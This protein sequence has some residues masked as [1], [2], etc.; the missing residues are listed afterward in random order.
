MPARA[1]HQPSWHTASCPACGSHRTRVRY[2]A[3]K[4]KQHAGIIVRH[5]EC[6]CGARWETEQPAEMVTRLERRKAS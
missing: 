2:I 3:A 4:A 5:R 1:R 6:P